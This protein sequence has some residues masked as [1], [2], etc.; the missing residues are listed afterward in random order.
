MYGRMHLLVTRVADQGAQPDFYLVTFSERLC[1]PIRFN[2]TDWKSDDVQL[3]SVS[4]RRERYEVMA[5][6][7]ETGWIES[8]I[9]PWMLSPDCTRLVLSDSVL[10]GQ[11]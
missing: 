2:K 7:K 5:L 11:R 10:G 6:M 8:S 4:V 3:I 9:G 1:G